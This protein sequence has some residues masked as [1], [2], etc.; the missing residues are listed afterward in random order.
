MRKMHYL[1]CAGLLAALLQHGIGYA[2][3][4]VPAQSAA[5]NANVGTASAPAAS[6]EK[7]VIYDPLAGANQKIL[8]KFCLVKGRT[9]NKMTACLNG[10]DSKV[11]GLDAKSRPYYLRVDKELTDKFFRRVRAY[12]EKTKAQIGEYYVAKDQSSVWRVDG[13]HP[14]MI[15]GSAEKVMKK[16][17]LLVYPRYLQMGENGV[18]R[19]RTPGDVPYTLQVKSLNEN[20]LTVDKENQ[21]IPQKLGKT[22]ILVEAQV[23]DAKDTGTAAIYVVTKEEL[24]QLAERA[25]MRRVYMNRM[26]IADELYWRSWWGAPFYHPYYYGHHHRPPRHH[27]K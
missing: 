7:K 8:E 3:E 27:H 19:L 9:Y 14:G 12:D 20:I 21:L 10:L 4:A 17:K 5:Q 15:A 22:D 26:L 2:A 23:G 16:T 11:T 13:D 24:Q 6:A 18:V 1:L 25:Y